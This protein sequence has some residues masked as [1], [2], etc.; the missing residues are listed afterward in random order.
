MNIIIKRVR[1]YS[2]RKDSKIKPTSED[3]VVV[4]DEC[5]QWSSSSKLF[6]VNSLS[7][8]IVIKKS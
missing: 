8:L 1:E 6:F 7:F 5:V 3:N 2:Y 4:E